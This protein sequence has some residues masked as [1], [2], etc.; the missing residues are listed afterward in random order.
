LTTA[1]RISPPTALFV[2]A[3]AASG[4]LLIA[5]QSHLTFLYDD[6]DPLLDRRAWS[7]HDLLRPHFEHIL[8]ATTFVF[9]AIQAT[10]GME[11]LLP[12]AVASTSVF[13]LSAALLFVY[14]RRRVGGW[15][16]LAGVLPILFLGAAAADLLAPFQIFFFGSM[17]CGLGALLAIEDRGSRGDLLAC[18]LLAVSFTF[19][20]LALPF[21]LGV[22]VAIGLDRGPVRRAYVVVVPL[23]LYAVWYAGWGH[24]GPS[25]LSFHNIAY[26]LGYVLDGLASGVASLLGL[27]SGHVVNQGLGRPLLLALALMAALRIRSGPPVSRWFW[28]S[29]VILL[30][31]WFLTAINTTALRPPYGSRYQYIGAVLLLMVAADLA[32]GVARTDRTVVVIALGV[33]AASVAGNLTALRHAYDGLRNST[34]AERGGLTGLE[35][36]SDHADP[37]IRLDPQN[38]G[39]AYF[40]S[41]VAGPYLSAVR[42]FG[43]PSY[44]ESELSSAP[45]NARVSADLVMGSVLHPTLHP[46]PR[47]PSARG[48]AP[49][50]LGPPGALAARRG[51]CISVKPAGGASPV[52]AVPPGGV[53][54]KAA[55]GGIVS[56]GLRRFATQSF[57]VSAGGLRGTA[58]LAIPL[59]RSSRP[60]QLQLATTGVVTACRA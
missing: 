44:S 52:I 49:A 10:I 14:M 22:A 60:W 9:K 31:F 46:A 23:L 13:L 11:S 26:S 29:L 51:G 8:L 36:E 42:E 50:L 4:I 24:T 25:N 27:T 47:R 21:V 41:I 43:S 38:S 18:T 53:L 48:P 55:P 19:S 3:A 39:F 45:E 56:L 17:A 5:W 40:D 32:D 1:R 2:L 54:L 58:V 34:P 57:P 30:S 20:E 37:A 15:L 12:Y 16:A 7:A 28:V 35:I 33:A 59:D 6:W